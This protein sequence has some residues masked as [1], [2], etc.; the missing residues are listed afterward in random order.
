MRTW[1][2]LMSL[3]ALV[4]G[5][6]TAAQQRGEISIEPGS[7]LSI[8]L[9]KDGAPSGRPVRQDGEWTA[10]DLFVARHYA[11]QMPPDEPQAFASPAPTD[12]GMPDPPAPTPGL[13]RLRFHSVAGRHS[14][15]ILENGYDRALTYRARMHQEGRTTPT[16]VCIVIPGRRNFEHWPHPVERLDLSA[17][18]FVVWREGDPVPCN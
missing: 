1:P 13:L 2:I 15:L 7:E 8:R 12:A 14:L 6:P 11:G 10:H 4:F 17:F 9:N 18:R 3:V 16:D 5:V